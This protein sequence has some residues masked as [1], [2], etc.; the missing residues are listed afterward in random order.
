[1]KNKLLENAI[2]KAGGRYPLTV[3]VQKRMQELVLQK[4]MHQK[5][6]PKNILE[7]CLHEVCDDLIYLDG[8]GSDAERRA[9][10]LIDA[11]RNGVLPEPEDLPT[12]RQVYV[13]ED[14]YGYDRF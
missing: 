6:L 11:A 4:K 8:L 14:D 7:Y 5:P 12:R 9:A 3:L 13:P 10:V 2:S 1:M